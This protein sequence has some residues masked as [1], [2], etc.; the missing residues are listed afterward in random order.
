MAFFYHIMIDYI[1]NSPNGAI[2]YQDQQIIHEKFSNLYHIKKKCMDAFFSYEGYIKAV[3]KRINRYQLIPIVIDQN[4]QW[5]PTCSPKSYDNIWI[6]Y[7]AVSE[8][9]P[10]GSQTLV[11]F[12]SGNQLHIQRTYRSLLTQVEDIVKIRIEKVKH[13]HG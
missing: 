1:V 3:N 13:F 12:Y 2:V 6:N 9:I 4:Q 7:A 5:I 10:M 11:C 8:M